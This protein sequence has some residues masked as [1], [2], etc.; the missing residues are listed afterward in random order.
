MI[1]VRHKKNISFL[2]C[3]QVGIFL[4]ILLKT[5]K[6]F[7]DI[8]STISYEREHD[9]LREDLQNSLSR[10]CVEAHGEGEDV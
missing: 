1:R 3:E 9:R 4:F 7:K 6:F 10:A 5:N 2:L 8:D